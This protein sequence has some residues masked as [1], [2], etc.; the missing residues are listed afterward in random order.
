MRKKNINRRQQLNDLSND[1]YENY[2]GQQ[3]YLCQQSN[4]FQSNFRQQFNTFQSYSRQQSNNLFENHFRRLFQL[5]K[6]YKKENKFS[7]TND[8]FDFKL[9]IFH[10]KCRLISLS[11]TAY[12]QDVESMLIDEAFAQFYAAKYQKRNYD[13]FLKKIRDFYKKSE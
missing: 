7:E 13:D 4:N 12:I 5:N 9:I 2:S 3:S 1:L 6:L 8:N 10:N 11:Q